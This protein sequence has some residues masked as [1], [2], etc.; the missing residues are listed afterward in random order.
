LFS[1]SFLHPFT[2]KS[3]PY[4]GVFIQKQGLGAGYTLSGPFGGDIRVAPS[5]QWTPTP[6]DSN[7]IGTLA[8]STVKFTSPRLNTTLP[9]TAIESGNLVVKGTATDRQGIATVHCQVLYNGS[10]SSP[11]LATGTTAWT[12]AI[13]TTQDD[14]GLYTV[15]AVSTDTTGDQSEVASLSFYLAQKGDL[16]INVSGPGSVSKGFLGTS[17]RDVGRLISIKATPAKGKTF[18]GWTG[19]IVS[20]SPTIKVLMTP[21][22]TLTANFQ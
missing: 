11:A 18:T 16:V 12:F 15:Y 20:I 8:L 22:L 9:V 19:D 7:P 13:P 6:G 4:S 17:Q 14:G 2:G 5:P 10:I 21:N 3:T 1:G